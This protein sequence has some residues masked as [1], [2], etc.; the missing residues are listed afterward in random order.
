GL[1]FS[2]NNE[3]CDD[4]NG[5]INP[6]ATDILDNG[7][8]ENCDGV[9]GILGIYE[10][11]MAN[12]ELIP[13]PASDITTVLISEPFP[14]GKLTI[15]DMN[16]KT[17]NTSDIDG[18]SVLNININHLSPGVYMVL[19]TSPNSSLLKRLVKN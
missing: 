1:G 8:D 3:D 6:N 5:Q 13:N 16:G 10:G 12:F 4:S 19:L 18:K 7:I 2:T 9:D 14:F 11:S 15:K 17:L